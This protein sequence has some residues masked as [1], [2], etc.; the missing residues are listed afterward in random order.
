MFGW[1]KPRKSFTSKLIDGEEFQFVEDDLY[2]FEDFGDIYN[3]SII[4]DINFG[5]ENFYKKFKVVYREA[6]ESESDII[7]DIF[8]YKNVNNVKEESYLVYSGYIENYYEWL[9]RLY[10]F[11]KDLAFQELIDFE[12]YE[13]VINSENA[14]KIYADFKK[15]HNES[16]IYDEHLEEKEFFIKMYESMMKAFKFASNGGKIEIF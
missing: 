10:E 14:K 2:L 6:E 5:K 9:N 3:V 12:D 1:C 8:A 11:K 4:Y 7:G 15:Y 16:K 13:R